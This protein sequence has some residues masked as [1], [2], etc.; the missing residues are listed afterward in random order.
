MDLR[1]TRVQKYSSLHLEA[2]A[3]LEKFHEDPNGTL[4]T[5]EKEERDPDEVHE[6]NEDE[7]EN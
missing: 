3:M 2:Q 7:D 6:D 4:L 5:L 1:K